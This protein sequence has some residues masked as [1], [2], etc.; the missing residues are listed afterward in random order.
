MDLTERTVRMHVNVYCSLLVW[1]KSITILHQ[2]YRT[3]LPQSVTGSW[4]VS[5]VL[6]ILYLNGNISIPM[7]QRGL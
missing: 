3:W 5:D 1:S 6:W 4:T 7:K 2:W